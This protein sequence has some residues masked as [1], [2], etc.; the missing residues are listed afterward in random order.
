MKMQ[1]IAACSLCC[2]F[3]ALLHLLWPSC[4]NWR[5]E[6]LRGLSSL[7]SLQGCRPRFPQ[8]TGF[9]STCGPPAALRALRVLRGKRRLA[10]VMIYLLV[11]PRSSR[12]GLSHFGVEETDAE[13]VLRSSSCGDRSTTRCNET[14][15]GTATFWTG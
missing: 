14:P 7:R 2:S 15:T 4:G 12:A 3:G 1:E 13:T 10:F 11:E 9:T 5:A 6:G 8:T